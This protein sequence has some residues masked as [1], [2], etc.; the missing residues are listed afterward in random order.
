MGGWRVEIEGKEVVGGLKGA[1]KGRAREVR[2]TRDLERRG[3]GV[4]GGRL[5]KGLM[6]LVRQEGVGVGKALD[7]ARYM[8]GQLPT[9]VMLARRGDVEQGTCPCPGCGG[10]ED[11][12]HVVGECQGEG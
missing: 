6:R 11:G 4:H 9:R 3:L 8:W 10:V 7:L 12:W 1:I 2:F 5:S